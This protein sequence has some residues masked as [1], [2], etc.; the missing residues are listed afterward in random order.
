MTELTEQER[1]A[2][3]IKFACEAIARGD[4]IEIH[5]HPGTSLAWVPVELASI[6]I[7]RNRYAPPGQVYF[8]N[9]A[10]F[11]RSD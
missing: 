9:P 8:I 5:A 2:K 4:S 7:V 11:S 6:P 1:F 3:A 10:T